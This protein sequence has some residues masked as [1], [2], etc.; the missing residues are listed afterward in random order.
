MT[1]PDLATQLQRIEAELRRLGLLVGDV[2]PAEPVRAAFGMGEMTFEQ[3]LARVFLPRALEAAAADDW[4]RAS[5][6]GTA[7]I[8]NLD[9]RDECAAL[10]ALLC[11][12]DRLVEARGRGR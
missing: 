8:R 4:P 10:V 1:A 6:V 11:E 12:F 9:G 5:N 2:G 3:W 7:A